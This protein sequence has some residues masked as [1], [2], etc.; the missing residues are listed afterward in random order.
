MKIDGKEYSRAHVLERLGNI[1][2]IGGARHYTLSEGRAQ[3]L[4]AVDCDT[5]A[6]LRFTVLPDRG[7]DISL[8]SYKGASLVHITAS[9]EAHPAF[10]EPAGLGWLRTFFG[11]LL[12]TCGLTYIGAPGRDGDEDL[13]LH[14]RYSCLPAARVND[15]SRWEGDEYI[16]ELSGVVEEAVLF[17]S[18][19]R[20]TRRITTKAGANSLRITDC[21]ENFGYASS[22]FTILY[23]I[24]PGFPL[25]DAGARLHL[26]EKG[27]VPQNEHAREGMENRFVFSAPQ[28]GFQEMVWLHTVKA[29]TEGNAHALLVNSGLM[30]GLALHIAFSAASL[31]YFNE[32]KMMGQG[33]YVIG[34]EPCNSPGA[35]RARVRAQGL[36]PML[37]PG[38]QRQMDVEI[39]V[40]EG[41]EAIDQLVRRIAAI[42]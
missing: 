22:P 26:P 28:A 8:C 3:G 11:G 40:I 10:Y 12:T 25:L 35:N 23:H 27:C 37:A 21:A 29:D 2:Q 14:G 41:R 36:L 16:I 1:A 7:L 17:G 30:G 18:R 13:G 32:W 20:L 19:I 39:S 42:V 24:N 5:G 6:G 9:G 15:L 34:L 4:R 31:P 38:E 33:D